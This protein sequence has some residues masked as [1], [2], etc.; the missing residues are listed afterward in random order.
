M[1]LMILTSFISYF[2]YK[3]IKISVPFPKELLINKDEHIVVNSSI[4]EVITI[5]NGIKTG[6]AK[7]YITLTNKR[8]IIAGSIFGF[9]SYKLM[10]RS[11]YFDKSIS[12]K[13]KHFKYNNE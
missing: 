8:I 9:W 3:V 4:H 1:G 6:I 11:I 5:R 2:L 13:R 12:I 7:L 10:S